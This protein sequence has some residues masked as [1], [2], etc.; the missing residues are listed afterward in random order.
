MDATP[1]GASSPGG[2]KEMP[3]RVVPTYNTCSDNTRASI[4]YLVRANRLLIRDYI[5]KTDNEIHR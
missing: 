4:E 5:V 3:G 2:E 1:A